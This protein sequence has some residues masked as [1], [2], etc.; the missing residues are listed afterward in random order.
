M[1]AVT[2]TPTA[3]G[4]PGARTIL[5]LDAATCATSGLV[6]AIGASPVADLLDVGGGWVLGTG[7]F[8]L[9]YAAGLWGFA[10]STPRVQR[11]GAVL[12]AVGDAL[13]VT[14]SV[15]LVVT[16]T[17]SAAGN[18]IVL[19]VATVVAAI[20]MAKLSILRA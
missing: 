14:A 9:V 10:R 17:F 6:A 5:Q 19:A 2:Q 20:G 16:G 11:Q 8:L 7:V 13:W 18:A 3:D 1:A 15:A 4:R 12:T